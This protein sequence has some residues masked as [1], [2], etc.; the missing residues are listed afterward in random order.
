MAQV[1]LLDVVQRYLSSVDSWDVD[2]VFDTVESEQVALIAKEV[3]ERLSQDT[4]YSQYDSKLT[5]L[6][7]LADN[8]KPNYLTIPDNVSR[9]SESRIQYNSIDQNDIDAGREVRYLD[10]EYLQPHDFLMYVGSRVDGGDNTSV[11]EDVDGTKFVVV[12]NKA[13]RYC[14][15]FDGKYIIFDSYDSEVDSVLQASKS[16]VYYNYEVD[17][18]LEDNFVIPLPEH[19]TQGYIDMVKAEASETLRQEA[20]PSASRR[21]QAF[22]VKQRQISQKTGNHPSK[23][24]R[25]GRVGGAYGRSNKGREEF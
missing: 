15:S 9:I 19:M 7:S 18:L 22:K 8:T 4:N 1:T 5:T 12:T 17:F 25:Y 21:A 16:R 11:V 20:L 23:I 14:T 13:P 24:K 10:V 3:W 2:S 6:D